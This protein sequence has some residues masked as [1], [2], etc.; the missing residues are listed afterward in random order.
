MT[1]VLTVILL[2]AVFVI[3]RFLVKITKTQGIKSHDAHIKLNRTIG[4]TFGNFKFIKLKGNEA[5]LFNNFD[6]ITVTISRA[7]VISQTLGTMPKNILEGI[8]FSLLVAV[9]VFILW[10][11]HSVENVIPVITMY[12]LALY[13][14]LPA[15][16]RMLQQLNNI[17]FRQRAL[18]VVYDSINQYKEQEGNTPIAFTKSIRMDDTSFQYMTGSE[19][20]HNISLE[21]NKGEKVGITGESGG[22]KSTL[23][24]LIIGINKPTS[25]T[26]YIDDVPITGDNIR[27]WRNKI[28]YIPQNIYLF[29]GPVDEN[30]ALGSNY[31]K[32][33]IIQVLQMANIWEFLQAKDGLTTNV[34]EGGIQLSGGQ[35]QRIGIA[36]ALYNDPEIIVLDEA[37]SALDNEVEEKIMD[38]IYNVSR[39]KT[40]I[41]IAHRLSTIERCNRRIKIESGKIKG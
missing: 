14:I 15:I 40:L 1:I 29:D 32:N 11:Y 36:R 23:V 18:D 19:V 6:K 30:V 27:A 35:K 26:L 41:V 21:I 39:E 9:V 5:H 37:T 2:F 31:D 25:G 24:D 10:T 34:G 20:L 12:A 7:S 17:I 16:N 4:E 28:G 22:G 13:R 8:G 3:I 33:R 38:E